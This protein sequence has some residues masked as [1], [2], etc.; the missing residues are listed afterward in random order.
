MSFFFDL[1]EKMKV[2]V[3]ILGLFSLV[4]VVVI[5]IVVSIFLLSFSF[6]SDEAKK[7][8]RQ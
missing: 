3:E 6:F 5:G 4:V 2:N 8:E 1:N 7:E